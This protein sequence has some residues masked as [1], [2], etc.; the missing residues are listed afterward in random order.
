MTWRRVTKRRVRQDEVSSATC[1][2]LLLLQLQP[3]LVQELHERTGVAAGRRR[4]RLGQERRQLQG[5]R[6]RWR[7]LRGC[8]YC[9]GAVAGVESNG[10]RRG[11]GQ[12]RLRLHGCRGG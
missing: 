4:R 3:L 10:Q 2:L 9:S 7:R 1:L 11:D 5:G 6:G 8:Q 12:L